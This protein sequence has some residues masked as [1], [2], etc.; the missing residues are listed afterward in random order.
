M[1]DYIELPRRETRALPQLPPEL[2]EQIHA[3]VGSKD[4]NDDISKMEKKLEAFERFQ[5]R[6][7]FSY[8]YIIAFFAVLTCVLIY[9]TATIGFLYV[10][11][12]IISFLI[13]CTLMVN[14]REPYSVDHGPTSRRNMYAPDIDEWERFYKEERP[15][16]RADF[17]KS[18]N[19]RRQSLEKGMLD[20]KSLSTWI[21]NFDTELEE[22]KKY[23]PIQRLKKLQ[24]LYTKYDSKK[25]SVNA[26]KYFRIN[27]Q[28][29]KSRYFKQR[30]EIGKEL[31]KSRNE[32]L[33]LARNKVLETY[34]ESQQLLNEQIDGMD[35]NALLLYARE[36]QE[37]LFKMDLI[38]QE[39]A[40]Y[41]E[42]YKEIFADDAFNSI[43]QKRYWYGLTPYDRTFSNLEKRLS[44][45]I[46]E[47]IEW[48]D[49]L[50]KKWEEDDKKS[51]E[52]KEKEEERIKKNKKSYVRIRAPDLYAPS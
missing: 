38:W 52:E 42:Q 11:P 30:K 35:N 40:H 22:I 12:A 2:W 8:P 13:M 46:N 5:K 3:F 36:I 17:L 29:A 44:E 47:K 20:G 34:E 28:D 1:G 15:T 32:V 24:T 31:V 51:L 19:D 25:G 23:S 39:Y 49:D 16:T 41:T 48:T 6:Y 43:F 9:C 26:A 33:L 37:Q 7:D 50:V 27:Q 4:L 45:T 21:E 10:F 14:W 18:Q